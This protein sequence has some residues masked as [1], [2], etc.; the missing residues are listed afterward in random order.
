VAEAADGNELI[1][2]VAEHTPDVVLLDLNMPEMDGLEAA[3]YLRL[4]YPDVRIVVLTMM[5]NDEM[6]LHMMEKGVHSYLVK[7]SSTGEII[8]TIQQVVAQGVYTNEL[9]S[10]AMLRK[11]RD[12]R[13]GPRT[14]N[15]EITL[16]EREKEV[17]EL[18]CEGL[19]SAQIGERLFISPRTAEG[20]RKK[21]IAKFEVKNTAQLIIKVI[22]GGWL[23][24]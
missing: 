13:R 15:H 8:E 11:E 21:L 19:T 6:I 23:H 9:M 1:Q 17:L 7:N 2:E 20:H 16:T 4:Q 12:P 22:K 24:T 18:I 10:Q 3:D 5:D 14:L